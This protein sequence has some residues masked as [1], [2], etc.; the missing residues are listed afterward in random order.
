MQ[1]KPLSVPQAPPLLGP[2]W[3][4]RWAGCAVAAGIAALAGLLVA[5]LMPRG[6][7][8]AIEALIVMGLGLIVGILA[9]LALRSRWALLLA[10]LAYGLAFELGRMGTDGPLVDGLHL[11]SGYGILALIL[12]RGVHALMAWF[13]M[14]LGVTYG[15]ALARRLSSDP[16]Q[17]RSAGR[18][19][20]GA[21]TGLLTLAMIGLAVGFALPAS[22]P[23]MLGADGEP[24]PGSVTTLEKVRLGDQDQWVMIRAADP[25][26]PVLLY[27]SGGPGQSDLPYTRV[28]FDDLARDFVLVGW[29]QRGTGKSYPALDP[30]S[31]LTLDRA[32]ADTIEL[33]NWLRERFDE[34]KIYLLGE[35]WGS[36]LGVFAAQRQPELYYAIIGSG[37]MVSQRETD[38]RIYR[39]LLD[40]AERTGDDELAAT[41]RSFGEPPYGNVFANALVMTYYEA[42]TEPYTPPSAYIQRGQ[43]AA[44]GPWGVL[45]S[46]YSLIEKVNVLRGLI[47][48]F[49]V[50]YPQLQGVDFRQDVPQLDVPVY[51]LDGGHELS[52]RR[53]LVMEWF[54]QLQAPQKRLFTF[55][56]AGHSTAFEQFEALREIMTDTIVPETYTPR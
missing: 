4:T 49:S 6:P 27:L 26:K 32:V 1:S 24:L 21:V 5:L 29:D 23:P 10:P 50:L 54:E 20:R 56:N 31:T 43:A 22:T 51:I 35:S 18:T 36:T 8:T 39:D 41:L 44:L 47:D 34:E 19:V 9:G 55:E 15:I 53:D 12:G 48:M 37:Q 2:V 25:D 33:T 28:L 38:R 14:A 40:Y 7:A 42:L 52:A 16:A 30:T 11:D 17:P 46:E 3:R 45:A 13:P